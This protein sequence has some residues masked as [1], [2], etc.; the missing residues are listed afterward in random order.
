MIAQAWGWMEY[1]QGNFDRARELFQEGIWA[2]SDNIDV[3]YVFQAWGVLE[4]KA[5]NIQLARELFKAALRVNP[6]SEKTWQTWIS[7]EV[8]LGGRLKV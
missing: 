6:Q 7:M 3:V 1:E 4:R 2:D 8:C 5:G